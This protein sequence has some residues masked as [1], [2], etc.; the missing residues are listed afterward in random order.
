MLEEQEKEESSDESKDENASPNR[1]SS[2]ENFN[3]QFRVS[4]SISPEKSFRKFT[5]RDLNKTDNEFFNDS[6]G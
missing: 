4:K 3:G 5:S 1:L 6:P 2:K